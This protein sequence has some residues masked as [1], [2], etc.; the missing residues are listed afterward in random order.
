MYL[1]LDETME[2]TEWGDEL[3]C[4]QAQVLLE[5]RLMN[6]QKKNDGN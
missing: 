1:K 5:D 6:E 4:D 2:V 3:T